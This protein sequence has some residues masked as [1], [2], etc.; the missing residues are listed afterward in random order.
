MSAFGG[1]ADMTYCGISLSRSLS[2]VKRTCLV[3]SH[4][5]AFDPMRTLSDTL[6]RATGNWIHDTAWN[7]VPGPCNR[8]HTSKDTLYGL[9]PHKFGVAGTLYMTARDEYLLKAAELSAMAQAETDRADKVEFEN[10]ARA[11]LRLAE[12]AERNSQADI[13]SETPLK[14]DRDQA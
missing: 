4:M 10:L 14:K 1:K 13:V 8:N 11:Y 7:R 3:A 2:G 9:G 5:S 12:Q 6:R